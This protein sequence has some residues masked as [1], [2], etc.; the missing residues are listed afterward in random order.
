ML[1]FT[2]VEIFYGY[3]R[4]EAVSTAI[5]NLCGKARV[6]SIGGFHVGCDSQN[7]AKQEAMEPFP[8]YCVLHALIAQRAGKNASATVFEC[9]SGLSASQLLRIEKTAKG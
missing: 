6:S 3:N 4:A 2:N 7:E 9:P 5:G 1:P 8:S